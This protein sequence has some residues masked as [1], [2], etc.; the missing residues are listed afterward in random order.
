[1]II[2]RSLF[3]YSNCVPFQLDFRP[4]ARSKLFSLI[5]LL[6]LCFLLAGLFSCSSSNGS[7]PADTFDIIVEVELAEDQ[8]QG[9]GTIFEA[10]DAR[11][12]LLFGAGFQDSYSTYVRDNN[13]MLSFFYNNQNPKIQIGPLGKPLGPES[14][15]TRLIVD[16]GVFAFGFESYDYPVRISDMQRVGSDLRSMPTGIFSFLG[17][18]YIG[19]K[20]LL[21]IDEE[22][23][24]ILTLDGQVIYSSADFF[25]FYYSNGIVILFYSNPN[26]IFI[27]PWDFSKDPFLDR[28]IL[29]EYTID[30][31]P[32]AFGAYKDELIIP[33]N[34]G[35]LY[36]Y[37]NNELNVIRESDGVSSW[38]I[39]SIINVSDKLLLGHYPT[40][41]LYVYDSNGLRELA[42]PIPVPENANFAEREAQTLTLFGGQL[43]VGLWPWGELWRFDLDELQWY[44]VAHLFQIPE[45]SPNIV[46]PYQME[47]QD[48]G[49]VY[50]YWGQRLVSM[51][52]Y[53]DA[54][55]ISTMNKYGGPYNPDSHSFLTTESLNQYG[56]VYRISGPL[57]ITAPISWRQKTT[58]RFRIASGKLE[59]YQDGLLLAQTES[60]A[61]PD[62]AGKVNRIILGEGV[63]G[64]FQGT[65]LVQR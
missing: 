54:L 44:F 20:R 27:G 24:S 1:M 16:D 8:G 42:P 52:P 41:S 9:L 15:N 28:S 6:A 26:R 61:L 14:T 39:Y 59:M 34:I 5:R 31:V 51:V 7:G 29:T 33:T 36:S 22:M 38:Q 18:Q 3:W 32:F 23:E 65:Q 64:T 62:I 37:Q 48:T 63:Y 40:G 43:Y 21:M 4:A 57:Q 12:R 35:S 55:Y 10:R 60:S 13:R 46:S 56:Q 49:D 53:G 11:N 47:M 45:M 19:N 17:L 30:G 58:F 25:R 2:G 50:N